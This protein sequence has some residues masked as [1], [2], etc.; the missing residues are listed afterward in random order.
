MHQAADPHDLSASQLKAVEMG[1]EPVE[2]E[3]TFEASG[4]TKDATLV[5]TTTP[6]TSSTMR[7]R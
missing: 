3:D 2:L 1:G 7:F 6:V 5:V 4:V